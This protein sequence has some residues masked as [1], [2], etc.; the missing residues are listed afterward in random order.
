[1]QMTISK[2]KQLGHTMVDFEIS[3]EKFDEMIDTYY[4]L[5]QHAAIP[6]VVGL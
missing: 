3:Q 2:L 4:G 1:M 5:A 6:N